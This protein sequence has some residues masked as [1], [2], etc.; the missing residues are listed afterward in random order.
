MAGRAT[1]ASATGA[2]LRLN[3]AYSSWDLIWSH[4]HRILVINLGIAAANLPLLAA[5]QLHHHPW[6]HPLLFGPLLLLT[7]PSLAA[8]FAYLDEAGGSGQPPVR[9]YFRAYARLF[10]PAL[11][12]SS[13]YLL[14]AGVAVADVV[15]LRTTPLGPPLVPMAAVVAVLALLSHIVSL[16]HVARHGT[17]A[18]GAFVLVPFAVVRHWF[19]T[20]VNLVL[21]SAGLLLVNQAPLLGLAVLPGCVLSVLWHN[22][23]S[24]PLLTPPP[25]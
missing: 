22:C 13:P 9:A 15:M 18:R 21:L 25:G 8:A 11:L 5:L 17:V 14:A 6:R 23:R 10:R 3:V 4:V 12:T 2:R 7:G 20:L 1:T 16:A 19:L 24:M